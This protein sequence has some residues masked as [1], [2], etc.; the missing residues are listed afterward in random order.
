MSEVVMNP[1]PQREINEK[2]EEKK[3][4]NIA[5]VYEVKKEKKKPKVSTKI[6]FSRKDYHIEEKY[7]E[8]INVK[9]YNHLGQL[10]DT[11]TPTGRKL[12]REILSDDFYS[13]YVKG[14]RGNSKAD[15]HAKCI[16]RTSEFFNVK[17]DH[18]IK[19][20]SILAG[21]K[22]DGFWATD[23]IDRFGFSNGVQMSRDQLRKAYNKPNVQS[24]EVAQSKIYDILNKTDINKAYV[25]LIEDIKSEFSR[26]I[27]EKSIYG[28]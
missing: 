9:Q 14:K 1:V 24:V 17:V 13:K 19:A 20:Y 18:I 2:G 28:E 21:K 26:D 3:D 22:I 6:Q 4:S 7:D 25:D 8:T 27:R 11:P 23:L 10:V 12:T 15:H 16:F 5:P